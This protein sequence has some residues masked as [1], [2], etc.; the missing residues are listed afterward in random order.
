MLITELNE[1]NANEIGDPTS[2]VTTSSS[3]N[4][5]KILETKLITTTP[6]NSTQTADNSSGNLTIK[7]LTPIGWNDSKKRKDEMT[8]FLMIFL[9]LC[10]GIICVLGLIAILLCQQ[11]TKQQTIGH[12]V[13]VSTSKKLDN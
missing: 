12:S 13:D 1:L 2:N 3:S 7:S 11:R 10:F 8:Q 9:L 4:D 5:T 6:V